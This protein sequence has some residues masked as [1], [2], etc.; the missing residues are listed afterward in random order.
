M[1]HRPHESI[2]PAGSGIDK[3]GVRTTINR[4]VLRYVRGM[5]LHVLLRAHTR[6]RQHY[7]MLHLS[8][9]SSV[10]KK[11]FLRGGSKDR[12]NILASNVCVMVFESWEAKIGVGCSSWRCENTEVL[13]LF[14]FGKALA[15][16]RDISA[17]FTFFF[18][19]ALR[20]KEHKGKASRFS[21]V[22]P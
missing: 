2:W 16:L 21:Y 20:K 22:L 10:P 13:P 4:R 7:N 6:K 8:F 12:R 9:C 11:I 1:D 15:I 19:D 18:A 17:T 5:M 3:F 14:F